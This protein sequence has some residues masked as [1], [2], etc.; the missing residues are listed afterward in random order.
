MQKSGY[1]LYWVNAGVAILLF[2]CSSPKK[3]AGSVP[4][5]STGEDISFINGIS[6]HRD[7]KASAHHLSPVNSG[8]TLP[9]GGPDSAALSVDFLVQLKYSQLLG[10]QMKDIDDLPL[11]SYI[12]QWWGTP[13]RYG[14]DSRDGIDCSAFVQALYAAVFHITDLPRTSREQFRMVRKIR[15]QDNLQ[16]GDLVFFHVHTRHVSHVGIY[17]QNNKFVHASLTQGIT[18]SDLTDPYWHRFYVCG[19]EVAE[20]SG[21]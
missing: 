7:G 13:Y 12:D 11:Y 1:K 17:L 14:G 4:S 5:S 6:I 21:G 10:V 2:A 18:I 19:G 8:K 3:I 9:A 15:H 20:N 16:E